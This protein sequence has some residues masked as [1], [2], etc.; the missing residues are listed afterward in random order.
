MEIFPDPIDEH[1]IDNGSKYMEFFREYMNS[2]PS[3][4]EDWFK[5]ELGHMIIEGMTYREIESKTKLNKRYITESIKQLKNDI[6]I[7]YNRKCNRVD[8]DDI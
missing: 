8:P 4:T 7:A 6:Y 5:R 3:T 2:K 1:I